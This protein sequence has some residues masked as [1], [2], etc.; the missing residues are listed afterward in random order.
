MLRKFGGLR[1]YEKIQKIRKAL[2]EKIYLVEKNLNLFVF[3]AIGFT[4]GPTLATQF[5]DMHQGVFV[6]GVLACLGGGLLALLYA[7]AKNKNSDNN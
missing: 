5:S 1:I 3:L 4:A 2:S 6:A 7:K